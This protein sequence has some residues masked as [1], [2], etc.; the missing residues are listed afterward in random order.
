[1]LESH[2]CVHMR[3]SSLLLPTYHCPVSCLCLCLCLS[4]Q[5][6]GMHPDGSASSKLAACSCLLSCRSVDSILV[7]VLS[8]RED[9]VEGS[10]GVTTATYCMGASMGVP[11]H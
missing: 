7:R 3:C 8:A 1:V 2:W 4:L 11:R 5:L 10:R 9:Q 6:E